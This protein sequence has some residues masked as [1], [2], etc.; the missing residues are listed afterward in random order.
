MANEPRRSSRISQPKEPPRRAFASAPVQTQEE[1]LEAAYRRGLEEGERQGRRAA[2]AEAADRLDEVRGSLAQALE[3]LAE[4]HR[5]MLREGRDA[6][7]RLALEAAGKMLR[8]AVEQEE[9]LAARALEEALEAL[10]THG[11][12]SVRVHPDDLESIR[13]SLGEQIDER[14]IRLEKD[15]TISRGGCTVVAPAEAGAGSLDAT[16]ETAEA[17]V[18]EAALE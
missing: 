16:I 7:V 11:N 17:S 3:G 15:G 12:F 2:E 18:R 9:P 10:P 1:L 13:E 4:A 14:E 6:M 8:R 5:E